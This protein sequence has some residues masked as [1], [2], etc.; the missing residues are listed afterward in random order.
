[1]EWTF[2]TYDAPNT[3]ETSNS[4]AVAFDLFPFVI[5]K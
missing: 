2:I 4:N 5:S 3:I 1:M